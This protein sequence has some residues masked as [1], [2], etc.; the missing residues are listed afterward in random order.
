MTNAA[1]AQPYAERPRED[2]AAVSPAGPLA[3][4]ALPAG[5]ILAGRIL[6][7]R[8][9]EGVVEVQ[10]PPQREID[11]S[12]ARAADVSIR[13]LS[14]GRQVP[15]LL[16]ITGA[17]GITGEGRQQLTDVIAASASV[18]AVVGESP[19]DRVIAH[20]LLRPKIGM[21]PGRFFTTGAEAVE[22]LG[23]QTNVE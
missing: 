4:G 2:V 12:D 20:S 1:V 17:L 16:L 19:V 9:G 15:M 18:L 14:G 23:Q 10:L 11:G 3:G 21:V 6:V 7:G 5:A 22:W 13:E 8:N